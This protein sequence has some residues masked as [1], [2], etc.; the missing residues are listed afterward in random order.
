[1]P[2]CGL[3]AAALGAA[4]AAREAGFAAG[5]AGAFALASAARSFACASLAARA[6]FAASRLALAASSLAA[7]ASAAAVLAAFS[8]SASRVCPSAGLRPIQTATGCSGARGGSARLRTAAVLKAA[9][10]AAG[11][12]AA[13]W[14]MNCAIAPSAPLPAMAPGPS[15]IAGALRPPQMK[16]RMSGGAALAEAGSASRLWLVQ[17]G[18]WVKA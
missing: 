5:L 4:L 7:R 3:R 12:A 15:S 2:D 17:P 14:P 16:G 10:A 18:D 11:E 6:S 1:M 13:V 9:S 8:C